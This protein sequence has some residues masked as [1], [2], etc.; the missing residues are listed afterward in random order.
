MKKLLVIVLLGLG[1]Q[2]IIQSMEPTIEPMKEWRHIIE[3][4]KKV[5]NNKEVQQAVHDTI[6]ALEK[7]LSLMVKKIAQEVSP[8]EKANIESIIHMLKRMVDAYDEAIR[9]GQ[10]ISDATAEEVRQLGQDL[11]VLIMP[12]IFLAQDPV[13]AQEQQNVLQNARSTVYKGIQ[14]LIDQVDTAVHA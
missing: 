13:F 1:M 3:A 5:A 10:E 4:S 6:A 14:H 8:S 2:G 7:T 12:L 11:M 9:T